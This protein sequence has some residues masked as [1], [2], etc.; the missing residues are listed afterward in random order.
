MTDSHA[1]RIADATLLAV[2]LLVAPAP[3]GAHPVLVRAVPAADATLASA[4]PELRLTFTQPLQLPFSS[5]DL[6][7]PSGAAVL[8]GPLRHARDSSSVVV[9]DIR[10]PLVPGTYKVAWKVAGP[11]G[12][13]VS[14]SYSFT[15][16]AGA[17]AT[18][19]PPPGA[20]PRDPMLP[21]TAEDLEERAFD[22][23]SPSFA[24]VRWLGFLGTFLLL[25]TAVFKLLLLRHVSGHAVEGHGAQFTA[26]AT[27]GAW[28]VGVGA[29][30]LLLAAAVVRLYAQ[31]YAF[32]GAEGAVDPAH[33]LPMLRG[34]VWGWAWQMQ[35]GAA[36]LAAI[37]FAR[38]R[39]GR[40]VGWGLIAVAAV[41]TA[42]IPAL[43]GHA[44]ATGEVAGLAVIADWLHVLGAGSWL[45]TL[46]VVV[47]VGLPAALRLAS[48]TRASAAARLV[49]AFSPLALLFAGVVVT[50]GVFSAWLHL[51]AL[52]ELWGSRYGLT[53]LIKLALFGVVAALGA[54]NWRRARP[55]LGEEPGIRRIRRSAGAELAGGA[56]VLAVTAVLV[57]TPPPAAERGSGAARTDAAS[58]G[59]SAT[60]PDASSASGNP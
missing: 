45:G 52:P 39:G 53:L 58:P 32:Y 24:A 6:L 54:Y 38:A 31:A 1:I 56:L 34:T 15:I 21:S 50:T 2:V 17:A 37:G 59:Q 7:S 48:G 40:T 9:A 57:A 41:V 44:M 28:R 60:R 29:T 5:I 10:G 43:S 46:V 22:A 11:D 16:L 51:G 12:H 42:L 19:P 33:V 8:L 27:T 47:I 49:N 13:P 23:G 3:A 20:S 36:L 4:P 14:G 30:L 35:V 25:G 18:A 26:A 55:A